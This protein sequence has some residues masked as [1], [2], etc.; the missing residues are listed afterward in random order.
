[1]IRMIEGS[2]TDE[3]PRSRTTEAI[4]PLSVG[5]D[6]ECETVLPS[7]GNLPLSGTTVDKD[8]DGTRT[9]AAW[10]VRTDTTSDAA[11]EGY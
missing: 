4:L 11:E 10:S 6:T 7:E 3:R 1:M 5:Q 2:L 9:A 8:N